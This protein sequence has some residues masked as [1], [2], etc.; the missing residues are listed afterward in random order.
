[1]HLRSGVN[2]FSISQVHSHIAAPTDNNKVYLMDSSGHLIS[3][4]DGKN[5]VRKIL[6]MVFLSV[7][8][9]FG[10]SSCLSE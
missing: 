2:R 8:V 4:L 7:L 10:H 5:V 1:M 9:F 6:F 3:V